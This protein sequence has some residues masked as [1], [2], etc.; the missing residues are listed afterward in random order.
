LLQQ[1]DAAELL[2]RLIQQQQQQQQGAPAPLATNL[3]VGANVV[4]HGK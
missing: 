2:Q 1:V 3:F 4:I